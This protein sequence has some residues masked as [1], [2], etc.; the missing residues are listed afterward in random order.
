MAD[1]RDYAVTSRRTFV[2]GAAA[3]IAA[4]FLAGCTPSQPS[5]DLAETGD[6]PSE[7]M[8]ETIIKKS[9]C[10]GCCT[11]E[12]FYN[13]HIRD[14]Q[15]VR[16]T[17]AD[18]PEIRWKG[19]CSKGLT[20]P[21]R[22]YSDN[23]IQYPLKR[24]GE[25]GEG[26]FDRISW[27]EAI[28][29]I[30]ENWK[31]ITDEYGPSA[32]AV[33][34]GAGNMGFM[35][36][37]SGPITRLQNIT[38]A[39]NIGM[40]VDQSYVLGG[41]SVVGWD[42]LVGGSSFN[43]FDYTNAII[44]WG[45]NPSIS[46]IQDFHWL[47]ETRDKGVP[48]VVIDPVYTAPASKA[49]LWIPIN[50]STDGVL[51]MGILNQILLEGKEDKEF[52]RASTNCTYLVKDSDG[53]FLRMSDLGVEPALADD[54]VTPIDPEVVWDE[55]DNTAKPYA[56]ATTPSLEG[57]SDVN[58]IAVKTVYN[59]TKESVAPYTLEKTS[60]ITGVSIDNINYLV[61]LYTNGP[62]CTYSSL[63]IDHYINGH[64]NYRAMSTLIVMTHNVGVQ[65]SMMRR[66]VLFPLTMQNPG[67]NLPTDKQGNPCQG[68]G[69]IYNSNK[70]YDVVVNGKYGTED[71]VLKGLYVTTAGFLQVGTNRLPMVEAVKNLDFIAVCDIWMT[72]SAQYADIVLP[73]CGWFEAMDSYNTQMIHPYIY[74]QDALIEPLFESKSNFEICKLIAEGLGYGE[75]FDLTEEEY[76]REQL[77]TDYA[78]GLGI[79]VDSLR[80]NSIMFSW[81]VENL[82][83]GEGGVFS[84]PDTRAQIYRENYVLQGIQE[85]GFEDR[86]DV[87]KERSVYWEPATE[88]DVNS[89]VREKF[90]FHALNEHMRTRTHSQW[91]DTGY[92]KEYYPE[93]FARLNPEDAA[94]L[95]IEEGDVIKIYNDRGH[96]VMKA[97]ISAGYPRN[98]IGIPRG[99]HQW[100]FIDGHFCDISTSTLNQVCNNQAFNDQAVAIEKM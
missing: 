51:A 50:A 35:N 65:G 83:C 75:F 44:G 98:M 6:Q 23:R 62:V 36:G 71:A 81:P 58:G 26:K 1:A 56:E 92:L 12:C 7:E 47:L 87:S 40:N 100:E 70:L 93:P 95:G 13:V 49:D 30:C 99:H 76:L 14:G 16:L 5:E 15:M 2:A 27:D 45:G 22:T 85:P 8:P 37:W 31:K 72:E 73:G 88:A 32:F 29:T 33:L 24:T 68:A 48:F 77:D 69:P 19:I 90:R 89:P 34:G 63:G 96:V 11:S 4:G 25:R 53:T 74:F 59:V 52:C 86:I 10:R 80:E 94:E 9:F 64:Y 21:M 67:A 28:S 46:N 54:G 60:E 20:Q 39:S 18:T 97:T 43:N 38:G 17:A 42:L 55:A 57:V 79:T 61:E 66:G 84:T 3:S 41:T 91:F 82:N 78:R